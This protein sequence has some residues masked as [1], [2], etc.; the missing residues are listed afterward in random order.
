MLGVSI[1]TG[2]AYGKYGMPGMLL[3]KR[4]ESNVGLLLWFLSFFVCLA[5]DAEFSQFFHARCPE[6]PLPCFPFMV[7]PFRVIMVFFAYG[8]V[9]MLLLP[10]RHIYWHYKHR[11]DT[12][13]FVAKLL[14]L[15]A[16]D[17][18]LYAYCKY[19]D[20]MFNDGTK[21]FMDDNEGAFVAKFTIETL[22]VAIPQFLISVVKWTFIFE[23]IIQYMLP[24]FLIAVFIA[25]HY[26]RRNRIRARRMLHE[27]PGMH[28]D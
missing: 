22:E 2:F 7:F 8:P 15:L 27:Y 14:A 17:M 26:V 9:S 13:T 28:L 20:E 24:A 6:D 23:I 5:T 10:A 12:A 21:T 4:V 16:I 11:G 25:I 3:S 18:W 19:R 1:L